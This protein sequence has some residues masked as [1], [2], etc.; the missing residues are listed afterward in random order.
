MG[1][2]LSSVSF[3]PWEV[4][5]CMDL[6]PPG[7]WVCYHWV[8]PYSSQ[9][10]SLPPWS[11]NIRTHFVLHLLEQSPE[12]FTLLPFLVGFLVIFT[13]GYQ[14]CPAWSLGLMSKC[15]LSQKKLRLALHEPPDSTCSPSLA[16]GWKGQLHRRALIWYLLLSLS[17][18]QWSCPDLLLNIFPGIDPFV[19]PFALPLFSWQKAIHKYYFL[20]YTSLLSVTCACMSAHTHPCVRISLCAY[21]DPLWFLDPFSF[22][23]QANIFQRWLHIYSIEWFISVQWFGRC[24]FSTAYSIDGRPKLTWPVLKRWLSG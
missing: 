9:F 13:L 2:H 10:L 15:L 5:K 11:L 23:S 24:R 14:G 21:K 3:A 19:K 7:S 8:R 12:V 4:I 1:L 17:W 16:G 22:L 6:E 20:R 18:P